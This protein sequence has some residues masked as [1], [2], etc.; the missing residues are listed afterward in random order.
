MTVDHGD[1][2]CDRGRNIMAEETSIGVT[3]MMVDHGDDRC[4]MTVMDTTSRDG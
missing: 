4:D 2:S 1:D 3:V